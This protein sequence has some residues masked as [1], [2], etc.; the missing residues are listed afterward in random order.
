MSCAK[1]HKWNAQKC[2]LWIAFDNIVL[3]RMLKGA[4]ML[5]MDNIF[6]AGPKLSAQSGNI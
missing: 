1:M 3:Q 4:E 5:K 6:N 2:A